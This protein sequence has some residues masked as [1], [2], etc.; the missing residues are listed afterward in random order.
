MDGLFVSLTGN[1]TVGVDFDLSVTDSNPS[2]TSNPAGS[3]PT[4]LLDVVRLLATT[5]HREPVRFRRALQ[6]AGLTIRLLQQ[7][8]KQKDHQGLATFA[9]LLGPGGNHE[10]T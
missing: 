2:P 4:P 7:M 3:P 10:E 1:G 5:N 6:Q 9:G 8:Y